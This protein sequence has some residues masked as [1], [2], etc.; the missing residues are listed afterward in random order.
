MD[1]PGGGAAADA[2][3]AMCA[4]CC[5]VRWARNVSFFFP[6]SVVHFWDILLGRAR[7]LRWNYDT[8]Y[9]HSKYPPNAFASDNPNR[10][11]ASIAVSPIPLGAVDSDGAPHDSVDHIR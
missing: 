11:D 2:G 8:R 9:F 5:H 4:G 6:T 7:R 10:A 1:A 3:R